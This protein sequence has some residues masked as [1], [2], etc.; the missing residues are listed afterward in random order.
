MQEEELN[1]HIPPAP[2][3]ELEQDQA[4]IMHQELPDFPDYLPSAA[5]VLQ[6]Q[7]QN[8]VWPEYLLSLAE[9]MG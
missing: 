2:L 7:Q 6:Q 9:A 4:P 5:E 1:L 3:L 8:F